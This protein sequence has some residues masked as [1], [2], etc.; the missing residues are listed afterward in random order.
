MSLACLPAILY[1]AKALLTK[2]DPGSKV[3]LS[4][5]PTQFMVPTHNVLLP[6][7]VTTSSSDHQLLGKLS[8]YTNAVNAGVLAAPRAWNCHAS[9]TSDGLTLTVYPR[10]ETWTTPSGVSWD[11]KA[12]SQ[13]VGITMH[14]GGGCVSC[15]EQQ[16]CPY[17]DSARKD[18]EGYWNL[19]PDGGVSQRP[20]HFCAQP[21]DEVVRHTSTSVVE[22]RDPPHIAGIGELSGGA[23]SSAGYIVLTKT[24][25]V[26]L[27]CTLPKEQSNTCHTVMKWFLSTHQGDEVAMVIKGRIHYPH[28]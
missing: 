2:S 5:C 20:D 10:Y 3:A 1:S 14:I 15:L 13:R 22:F 27:S 4:T 6:R 21:R 16:T 8:L 25:D 7:V 11:K 28:V 17:F 24:G 19:N 23:N 18:Y 26:I 12:P 9:S